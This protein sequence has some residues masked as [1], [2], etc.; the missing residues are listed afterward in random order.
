[1]TDIKHLESEEL[2]FG[3]YNWS[4]AFLKSILQHHLTLDLQFVYSRVLRGSPKSKS[5]LFF[6]SKEVCVYAYNKKYADF[7][8]RQEY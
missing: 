2:K 8:K 6:Q 7:S 3:F 1:M 4:E 5:W